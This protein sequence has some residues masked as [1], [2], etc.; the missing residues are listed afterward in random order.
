MTIAPERIESRMA[1]S[2]EPDLDELFELLEHMPVP[3]GYKVEIVEGTVFMTPQRDTH[4]ETIA[5]IYEQ[6]RAKYP[7]NRIRS[8][9]R[10]DF[11]GHRNGF[12]PDVA[13][14]SRGARKDGLGRWRARDVEFVAEVIS[15]GTAHND[16]GPKM[17]AYA[18][19]GVPV[20]VVADPY[21]R[22]CRVFTR[23]QGREYKQDCTVEYGEPVDLT[24]TVVGLVLETKD[25]PVEPGRTAKQDAEQDAP[26]QGEPQ[27]EGPEREPQQA[28][29]EE[30]P[31][32]EKPREE[33]PRGEN[34]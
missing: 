17:N 23:P 31:Q 18:Q 9:V 12:A 4:W 25:F 29:Q 27:H 22:R 30:K 28:A 34:G 2:D 15:R 33:K 8:D 16:Y 13:L 6:L 11:P 3:D 21:L 7:R 26:Q 19:A 10:I 1:N 24:G 20:Y 32:E 14:L 5:D